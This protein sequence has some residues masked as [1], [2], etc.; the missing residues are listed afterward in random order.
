MKK[1]VIITRSI[2]NIGGAQIY[3]RNKYNYLVK[4]KI[5]DDVII[6]S[7]RVGEILIEELNQFK[8]NIIPECMYSPYLFSEN[9][10]EKVLKEL[11]NIIGDN[12]TSEVI[13][14]SN[15]LQGALWGELLAPVYQAYNF[16][17]FVD[18][19]FPALIRSEYQFLLFKLQRKELA[20]I[21]KKS[22]ELLFGKWFKLNE[23][24][25]YNLKFYCTNV[26]EPVYD[27]LN[28]DY[29][30]YDVKIGS[31]GRIEKE[32]VPKIIEDVMK[33]SNNN[34]NKRILFVIFGGSKREKYLKKKYLKLF[35]KVKNVTFLITGEMF[36]LSFE[37]INH[38]D[39][40][41]STAGSANATFFAGIPT[42]S[43]DLFT[44]IPLGILG[45][46]TNS[47]Q[48]RDINESNR[49]NSVF[50]I[51]QQIF[52]KKEINLN[53]IR[54]QLPKK[55]IEIDFTEHNNFIKESKAV[56]IQ[57]YYDFRNFKERKKKKVLITL[58]YGILGKH[59]FAIYYNF[60]YPLK[61]FFL[62]YK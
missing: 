56:S 25:K 61:N 23:T 46:T 4:N 36:P 53:D 60:Y 6:I 9:Q 1:Y 57:E 26:I 62:I 55:M 54:S 47:T 7:I 41:I 13:I 42:I 3:V 27:R 10:R 18:D 58:L 44:G 32:C 24:E 35:K 2:C 52:I 16:C 30:Q 39:I 33:F 22:L 14:E 29:L 40:F 20:G 43:V 34:K 31:V 38:F 17:F 19:M 49:W 48:Y 45:V 12:N 21:H 5:Y 8:K 59:L 11:E 15:F 28:I 37:C 51:L 50:E